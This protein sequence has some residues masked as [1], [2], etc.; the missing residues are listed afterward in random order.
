MLCLLLI[1]QVRTL[2]MLGV[3]KSWLVQCSMWKHDFEIILEEKLGYMFTICL[4]GLNLDQF[5]PADL[6][7]TTLTILNGEVIVELNDQNKNFSLRAED[8]FQVKKKE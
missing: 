4:L 3:D 1:F 2:R 8:V 6:G 7:N 5:I